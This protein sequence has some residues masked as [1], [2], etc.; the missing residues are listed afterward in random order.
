[1]TTRPAEERTCPLSDGTPLFYR[2]W[3]PTAADARRAIVLFHRG[4]EHSG[5]WQ[6]FIERVNLPDCWC[7]AWDARGHGRSPGERGYAESFG[8]LVADAD[9]F[10]RHV[11][12]EFDIRPEQM[13]VVAQSVGA[14]V[15]A[16]WVHDFAPSIRA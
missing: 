4:H 3:K 2:V 6:D 11:A 10:V 13:A 12:T 16:T 7:F 1:M 14:V 5:R 15:A 9:E 8:R